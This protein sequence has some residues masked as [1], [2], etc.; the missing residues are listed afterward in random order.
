MIVPE[1]CLTVAELCDRW[2]IDRR[3]LM[4]L[5]D[6]GRLECLMFLD[7]TVH[8]FKLSIVLRYEREHLRVGST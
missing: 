4:K 6:V 8:R 7:G 2:H 3:T 1:T 5:V